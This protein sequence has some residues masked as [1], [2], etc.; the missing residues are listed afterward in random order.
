MSLFPNP[1]RDGRVV[2][3]MSGLP[4]AVASA[5]IVVHDAAGRQVYMETV[6]VTGGTVN[7]LME[8]GPKLSQGLYMVEA[9]ADGHRYLL[10]SA[11]W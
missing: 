11:L 4:T 2:L 5:I 3:T 1:S 8:L 7:H 10:R 9:I 6:S